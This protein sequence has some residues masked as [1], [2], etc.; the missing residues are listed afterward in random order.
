MKLFRNTERK[1]NFLESTAEQKEPSDQRK[2]P[3]VTEVEECPPV[4]VH[5]HRDS[6]EGVSMKYFSN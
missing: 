5:L 2:G 6:G 3:S 1:G 4:L